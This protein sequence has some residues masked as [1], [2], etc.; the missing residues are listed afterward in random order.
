MK[1]PTILSARV[2]VA[3]AALAVATVESAAKTVYVGAIVGPSLGIGSYDDAG[4]FVDSSF[5]SS[6]RLGFAVGAIARLSLNDSVFF[7]TGLGYCTRGGLIHESIRGRDTVYD[8][9]WELDYVTIPWMLGTYLRNEAPTR[10]YGKAGI[11][12]DLAASSTIDQ[13]NTRNDAG[14]AG[15]DGGAAIA[16]GMIRTFDRVSVL[17]EIVGTLGLTDV[18]DAQGAI[19]DVKFRNRTVRVLLGVLL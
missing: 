19:A 7:D 10:V 15:Q 16:L 12:L 11:E 4:V 6:V 13:E 14:T 17:G 1:C 8:I 9:R 2:A 5:K 3:I 18:S